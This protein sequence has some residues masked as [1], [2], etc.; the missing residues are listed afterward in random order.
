MCWNWHY[1]SNT[2]HMT[3]LLQKC[4]THFTICFVHVNRQV[5]STTSEMSTIMQVPMQLIIASIHLTGE[6]H[7]PGGGGEHSHYKVLQECATLKTPFSG[8]FLA[9]ETHHFKPLS[10]SG[11]PHLFFEQFCIFIPDFC[12]FWLKFSSWDT[13]SGEK[14]VPTTPVSSQ[15]I[16]PGDP[17]FENLGGTYLLKTLF[18]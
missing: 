15:K 17:T 8:Q 6:E 12:Q 11:D 16:S 4:F 10:S 14:F 3:V 2:W 7:R 1:L 5:A 13:N 9:S 18:E